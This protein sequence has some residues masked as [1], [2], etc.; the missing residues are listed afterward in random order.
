MKKISRT[1]RIFAGFFF[2]FFEFY[3]VWIAPVYTTTYVY[4][5]VTMRA[6]WEQEQD[7]E[8]KKNDEKKKKRDE[9]TLSLSRC[10]TTA[11]V[12]VLG[13]NI[14]SAAAAV[15]VC[16]GGALRS[17]WTDGPQWV[18]RTYAVDDAHCTYTRR[19]SAKET[20][21]SKRKPR[22]FQIGLGCM[23]NNHNT[24]I[25]PYL[26]RWSREPKTQLVFILFSIDTV[27]AEPNLSN[28]NW[29]VQGDRKTLKF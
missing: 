14:L 5:R 20:N 23:I 8:R 1:R 11:T 6:F 9:P 2:F 21:G 16:N 13:D 18:T 10:P 28:S 22:R 17:I 3:R 15:K 24:G 27:V 4:M 12:K 29:R 19:A 26:T 7:D 25:I